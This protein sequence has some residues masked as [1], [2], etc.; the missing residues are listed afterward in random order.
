MTDSSDDET[1]ERDVVQEWA[2]RAR[3]RKRRRGG[4]RETPTSIATSMHVEPNLD[5]ADDAS[6][7]AFHDEKQIMHLEERKSENKS[8][9]V[10]KLT[11][12]QVTLIDLAVQQHKSVILMGP[13]GVGKT[14]ALQA[15][16][17]AFPEQAPDRIVVVL[18][19]T[20][21][22]VE[23]L[24]EQDIPA[25]TIHHF[26]KL[27]PSDMKTVSMKA[28]AKMVQKKL[29]RSGSHPFNSEISMRK[30]TIIL[31]EGF[32]I[33]TSLFRLME[34]MLRFFGN[35]RRIAGGVQIILTGDVRQMRPVK[36]GRLFE[37]NQ[38]LCMFDAVIQLKRQ[39][40][41][42]DKGLQAILNHIVSAETNTDAQ[43]TS[44][45]LETLNTCCMPF[46]KGDIDPR[47]QDPACSI[48]IVAPHKE[49]VYRLNTTIYNKLD[50]M[51]QASVRIDLPVVSGQVK[52]EDDNL[53]FRLSKD[54]KRR[55]EEMVTQFT[56]PSIRRMALVRITCSGEN[57]KNGDLMRVWAVKPPRKQLATRKEQM[58]AIQK[59]AEE[60]VS[61][62]KRMY[63]SDYMPVVLLIPVKS[64]STRPI[65]LAMTIFQHV[66]PQYQV[67]TV[68]SCMSHTLSGKVGR[69]GTKR[70]SKDLAGFMTPRNSNYPK[71]WAAMFPVQLG[72]ARTIH[73]VQGATMSSLFVE[74]PEK[75]WEA[76]MFFMLL[77]RVPETTALRVGRRLN[78]AQW[79]KLLSLD[80]KA[81]AFLRNLVKSDDN[82]F[83]FMLVN[84][85]KC[86][87]TSTKKLLDGTIVHVR[88]PRL[89]QAFVNLALKQTTISDTLL[90]H[91]FDSR[92]EG[93][94]T[95]RNTHFTNK[96]AQ[97]REVLFRERENTYT[98]QDG[99]SLTSGSKNSLT[100]ASSTRKTRLAERVKRRQRSKRRRQR[101]KRKSRSIKSSAE[102]QQ[103]MSTK[104]QRE[105]VTVLRSRSSSSLVDC[106][107]ERIA[108]TTPP[109]FT[110][111]TRHVPKQ[112]LASPDELMM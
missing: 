48:P 6:R 74:Q 43:L 109:P 80:S 67:Q 29:Q 56:M 64:P 82:P 87:Y 85:V 23:R 86:V 72:W 105:S 94:A 21:A 24:Q 31:E 108:L 54:K 55:V 34:Y 53:N 71:I 27:Q 47:D 3:S 76:G 66:I 45:M 44:D 46:G 37:N 59:E 79:N 93:A 62:G 40:R 35:A 107:R 100:P 103:R 16:I 68:A 111:A 7:S 73:S 70:V 18:A 112:V 78:A 36:D 42:Q 38:L 1:H 58:E 22:M 17:R 33:G 8:G 11:E 52:T 88:S 10:M 106:D 20:N 75:I 63:Y 96:N 83:P 104:R 65:Q 92:K 26:F 57:I 101:I 39:F 60:H 90:S 4:S 69:V 13:P 91:S 28:V 2:R 30:L 99:T 98:R 89:K 81:R 61:A 102:R 50:R 97:L 5:A 19:P 15:L 84:D 51:G 41:V 95:S 77:F 49:T 14:M 110:H 25:E 12:G 32:M 9:V